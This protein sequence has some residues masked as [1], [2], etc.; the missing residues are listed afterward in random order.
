MNSKPKTAMQRKERSSH[1]MHSKSRPGEQGFTLVEVLVAVTAGLMVSA[2]AFI[3]ARNATQFFQNEARISSAQLSAMLGIERLLSDLDRAAYLS[4]PNVLNQNQIPKTC[5]GPG[6]PSKGLENLAALGIEEGGSITG[7]NPLPQSVANGMNPDRITIGGSFDNN[8]V[9]PVN[10]IQMGASGGYTIFLSKLSHSMTRAQAAGQKIS[11]IFKSG[12]FIRL[13]DPQGIFEYYA[14]ISGTDEQ[15][16]AIYTSASPY[17][18][19]AS[20]SGCG[21]GNAFHIGFVANPVT[22]IRYDIRSLKNN[23]TY[24]PVVD[25][26]NPGV[27]G[28][29][30]RSELIRVE[31]QSNGN[32]D[33]NT[34]ELISEYAVDLKFGLSAFTGNSPAPTALTT[35]NCQSALGGTQYAC[36]I[37]M[38]ADVYS[39][40]SGAITNGASPELLRSVQV[41]L[42]TRSRAPD[43][44]TDLGTGPDGRKYRFRIDLPGFPAPKFTRLRTVYA[45]KYLRNQESR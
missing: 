10:L 4:T 34:L 9:F 22:R 7:S 23:N 8:D 42:V 13:V 33:P 37:P 45:E 29:D 2:A 11:N 3:L 31:L 1:R 41:R 15:Q 35:G 36:P 24:K 12:R 19:Q 30:Q 5:I 26:I 25:S 27:T 14:E 17:M 43:R 39:Q 44:E 21:L 20:D 40:L 16:L 18:P 6:T 32:E 38:S 28:D